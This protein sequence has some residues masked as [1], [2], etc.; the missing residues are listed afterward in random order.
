MRAYHFDTHLLTG[1]QYLP[2]SIASLTPN[3]ASVDVDYKVIDTQKL[4]H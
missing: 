1:T 3:F 2:M 4:A